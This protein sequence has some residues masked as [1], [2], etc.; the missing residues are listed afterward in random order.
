MFDFLLEILIKINSFINLIMTL[1]SN[2]ER[3]VAKKLFFGL[4]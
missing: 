2:I 4:K 3:K 1:L